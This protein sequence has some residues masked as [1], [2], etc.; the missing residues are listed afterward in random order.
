MRER[1]LAETAD[2]SIAATAMTRESK[3]FDS[4]NTVFTVKFTAY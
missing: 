3:L 4:Q 2:D 1:T